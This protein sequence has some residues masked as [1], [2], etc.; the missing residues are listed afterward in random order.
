M[1]TD[2]LTRQLT[3]PA[4]AALVVGQ[5]I[6]VGIFLTPGTII[7]TLASPLL[8]LSVWT[9]I[10]GIAIC[11]ALCYG[12]LAAWFPRAGG[13]Y[14]Y[15]R[16]AYGPRVA[17]L[18]GWKCFLVMDPGITAALAAGFATYLGFIIPLGPLALRLTGVSA[19]VV[20]A[21]V[22]IAGVKPGTRLLMAL[23]VA[24]LALVFGLIL[25]AFT[26]GAGD[27]RHF[28][29]F[30]SRRPDA[31]PLAAAM[32]GALIAA[33]FSFGGWWEVTKISARCVT[34][35]GPCPAPCCSASSPLRSSTCSLPSLSSSSSQST[36]LEPAT[37]SSRKSAPQCSG[38]PAAP[39]LRSS[40]CSACS[41]AW[42]RC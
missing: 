13:G 17:F 35:H 30:V 22:H 18:Y 9:L 38:P 6:S 29:P 15:L 41:G 34:R 11:G 26:N 24:K 16:E 37:R 7:R 33:F 31:P 27:W 36:G 40:S 20:L 23:T 21:L 10:G 42:A 28:L 32:D 2:R 1:S 4:A 39:P 19:I 3:L 12:T 25:L 14:V 5:V 8:V